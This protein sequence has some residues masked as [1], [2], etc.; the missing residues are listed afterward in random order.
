VAGDVHGAVD[1]GQRAA[2]AD[3]DAVIAVRVV[4][5]QGAGGPA[6][7]DRVVAGAGIQVAGVEE[8]GRVVDKE[9]AAARAVHDAQVGHAARRC[10]A[11]VPQDCSRGQLHQAVVCQV[12]PVAGGAEV[13]QAA[14]FGRA[15]A[16]DVYGAVDA[17]HRAVANE[18]VV[19]AAA[20]VRA[21][22]AGG[23]GDEDR[24]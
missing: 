6:D 3:V 14:L 11:C 20:V 10:R 8:V 9:G 4:H 23:P 22:V 13:V 19:K 5:V 16:G 17:G 18:D 12:G 21:Q 15:A 7:E 1:V 24:V 2:A